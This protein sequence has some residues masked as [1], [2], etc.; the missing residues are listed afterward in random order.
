M[1][2]QTTTWAKHM[3]C[4]KG[5]EVTFKFCMNV[6]N[7]KHGDSAKLYSHIWHILCQ[8]CTGWNYA[9]KWII[10]FSNYKYAVPASLITWTE[11]F[12]VKEK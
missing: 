2:G 6:K 9:Q 3:K 11:A 7:Y 10:K 1:V 4:Y 8:V 12:E 5:V